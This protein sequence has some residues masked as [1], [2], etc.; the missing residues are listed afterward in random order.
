MF[1]T[2]RRHQT[3]LWAIIITFTVISFVI[4]FNPSAQRGG[5]DVRVGDFG[6]IGGEKITIEK[7][8]AAQGEVFLRYFTSYGDWPDKDAKN[9]GFD[10][11]R[12]T[13]Y[14]LLLLHKIKEL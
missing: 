10:V 3:W 5:G 2:M 8:R 14:R 4:Y 9:A 7:F 6:T 12:E 11:E 1:G 13:F